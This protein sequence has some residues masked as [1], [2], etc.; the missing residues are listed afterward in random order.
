ME[1]KFDKKDFLNEKEKR[2]KAKFMMDLVTIFHMNC[3]FYNR[4]MEPQ[5]FSDMVLSVLMMFIR[6]TLAHFFLNSNIS[7]KVDELSSVLTTI[8]ESSKNDILK[9]IRESQDEKKK[10]H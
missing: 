1:V 3:N 7:D 9:L 5:A 10:A 6:D 8:F 4:E 2:Y